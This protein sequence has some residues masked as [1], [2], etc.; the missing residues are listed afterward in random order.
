M[1]LLKRVE[2]QEESDAPLINSLAIYCYNFLDNITDSDIRA[3]INQTCHASP[4]R[5]EKMKEDEEMKKVLDGYTVVSTGSD[6]ITQHELIKIVKDD[7]DKAVETIFIDLVAFS[8][9]YLDAPKMNKGSIIIFKTKLDNTEL[10]DTPYNMENTS[11][12]KF[13]ESDGE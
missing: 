10:E 13:D 12:Q 7:K 4:E 5:I 8:I 1:E 2:D 11:T 6:L 9:N 3:G